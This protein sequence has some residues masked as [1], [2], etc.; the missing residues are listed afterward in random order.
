MPLDPGKWKREGVASMALD[1]GEVD[2]GR[3]SMPMD[4]VRWKRE[5][6]V[7]MVLDTGK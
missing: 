7:S 6:V 1:P 2:A 3:G 4:L 5:G